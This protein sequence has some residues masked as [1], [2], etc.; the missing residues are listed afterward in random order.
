MYVDVHSHV[1]P[2]GDDGAATI[3]EGLALCRD[4]ADHGTS[5][6]YGTPHV[7][8]LD[9]LAPERELAVRRAHAVMAD[10]AADFGLELRLG[11]ELTPA[12]SL[13]SEPLARYVLQGL[14]VRTLLVEFPFT[15]DLDLLARLCDR[16]DGEGF[17]LVLAHPE[18]SEAVLAD[19]SCAEAYAERGWTLQVNGSSLL[20]RHG[21]WSE[22]LGWMLLDR[23]I[24]ALVA[25]DG[26]RA[27]RPPQLDRVHALARERMG[28]SA[29][30]LFD[31]TAL[32]VAGGDPVA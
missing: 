16:A 15:G 19:P 21:P 12:L 5:V 13:L 14:E 4:A 24:A 1:V 8:P 10:R 29:D 7:W 26:H 20:G 32:Q 3:D 23:G 9:G 11:F 2:S 27:T 6:L 30:R 18:R 25:S 31:G 28:D 17:G 22:E